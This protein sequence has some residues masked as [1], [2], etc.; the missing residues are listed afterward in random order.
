MR[1]VITFTM[2]Q[3]DYRAA[4]AKAANDG[5]SFAGYLKA[6]IARDMKRSAAKRQNGDDP[7]VAA[8]KPTTHQD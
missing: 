7:D 8:L 3:E 1:Q 4:Q 2:K 6:L 5:L